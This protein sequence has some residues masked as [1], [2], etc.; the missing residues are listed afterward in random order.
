M[1]V[2]ED[3]NLRALAK[4][5][6]IPLT[7]IARE[8]DLY[9][10]DGISRKAADVMTLLDGYLLAA[11]TEYGQLNF[12]METTCIGSIMYEISQDIRELAAEQN[13]TISTI[14]NSQ[15]AVTTNRRGLKIA[16]GC[17]AQ[18]AA[19]SEGEEGSVTKGELKLVSYE[20]R[21]GNTVAG[22]LS[23]RLYLTPRDLKRAD[24]LYGDSHIT[25]STQALGSGI[26]L[27]IAKQL[28]DSLG[29]RL[30]PLRRDGLGGIGLELVKSQQMQLV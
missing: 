13:I 17:L 25:L 5:L 4:E 1:S 29:A 21:N 8:A 14:T 23:S 12:P 27:A 3:K 30:L 11:Q 22:V 24:L 19:V 10:I 6:K 26:R 18:M 16:L 7:A 9:R 2:P 15:G 20:K 28:A